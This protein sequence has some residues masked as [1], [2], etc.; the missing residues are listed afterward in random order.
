MYA[1][2]YSTRFKRDLKKF[3]NNRALLRELERVLDLLT[4]GRKLP[5]NYAEHRLLGE[6]KDCRECH[7][8]PDVLLIYK[9][10]KGELLILLLR[11]GSHADLF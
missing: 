3:K 5:A 4:A 2:K 11:I 1:L 9:I 6:F 7:L 8:W 10:E